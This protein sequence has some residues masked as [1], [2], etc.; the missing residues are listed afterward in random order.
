MGHQQQGARIVLQRDGQRLAH[1]QVQMIARFVQYQQR[2]LLAGEKRQ[3][4]T[5]LFAAGKGPRRAPGIAAAEAPAAQVVQR[6][7]AVEARC[8]VAADRLE[9]LERRLAE[10]Q[11]LQLVLREVADGGVPPAQQRTRQRREFAGEAAQQRGLAGAVGAQHADAVVRIDAQGH[12]GEHDVAVVAKAGVVELQGGVGDLARP[13][14]GEAVRR[15]GMHGGHQVHLPQRLQAALHLLGLALLGAEA[16]YETAYL[17]HPQLLLLV[18]R[19]LARQ[20]F[21][22]LPFEG[23]VVADVHRGATVLDMHDLLHGLVEELAVVGD[24]QQRALVLAQPGLQPQRGFQVQMVGRLVQQQQVGRRHQRPGEVEAYSP[25]AGERPM[26]LGEVRLGEP[27]AGE[28]LAAPGMGVVAAG[29]LV[30]RIQPAEGSAV[31]VSLGFFDG[32]FH[33]AQPRVAVEHEVERRTRGWLHGLLQ[34]GDPPGIRQR[35]GAFFRQQ[36]SPNQL[37]ERRLAHAVAAHDSSLVAAVDRQVQAVEDGPLAA[38]QRD[39]LQRQH[40]DAP[41]LPM[42]RDCVACAWTATPQ[43]A[44]HSRSAHKACGADRA[45]TQ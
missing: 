9:V 43:P 15:L 39:V 13:G 44:A 22:P 28:D 12:V 17:R 41:P 29:I 31:V 38:M 34:A 1:F 36:A 45:C 21:R 14:E 26:R 18:Q 8:G 7:L 33:S 37:E 25:A 24:H 42:D 11:G 35:H 23:G 3:H 16:V 32:A 5:R 20:R 2:P 10:V 6:L 30:V 19:G 40:D 27:Q 4:Q